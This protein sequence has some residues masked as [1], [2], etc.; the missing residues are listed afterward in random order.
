MHWPVIEAGPAVWQERIL[1]L[2]WYQCPIKLNFY[3]KKK[4]GKRK[5]NKTKQKHTNKQKR[6]GRNRY[7]NNPGVSTLTL[8]GTP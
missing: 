8:S 6:Q 4:I 1:A 3:G 7:T 2:N 5:Q